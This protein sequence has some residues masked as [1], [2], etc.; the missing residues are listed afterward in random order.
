MK[1]KLTTVIA[2]LLMLTIAFGLIAC[3]KPSLSE[4]HDKNAAEFKGIED[5]IN[6][7]DTGMTAAIVVEDGNVLVLRYT[8]TE[9]F[10][11]SDPEVAQLLTDT[12]DTMFGECKLFCVNLLN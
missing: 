10:D 1:K 3:G 6:T 4:W 9:T 11:N 2:A 8:L 5:S 12:Y 7:A